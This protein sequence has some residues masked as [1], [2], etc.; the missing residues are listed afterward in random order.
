MLSFV[1]NFNVKP[2]RWLHRHG[3]SWGCAGQEYP[4]A[5]A[6]DTSMEYFIGYSV[7]SPKCCIIISPANGQ[8]AR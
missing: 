1:D 4:L 3:Y 7:S 8:P 6:V 2:F 5:R